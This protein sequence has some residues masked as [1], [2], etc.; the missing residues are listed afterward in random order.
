MVHAPVDKLPVL[1]MRTSLAELLSVSLSQ[2]AHT[3]R[4]YILLQP[5]TNHYNLNKSGLQEKA[6]L[7]PIVRPRKPLAG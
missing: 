4:I 2:V 3:P 1:K 5:G 7:H 6:S